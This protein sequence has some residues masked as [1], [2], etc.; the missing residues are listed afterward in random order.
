MTEPSSDRGQKT[1]HAETASQDLHHGNRK[2]ASPI[3][4]GLL[5]NA[6]KSA[7]SESSRCEAFMMQDSF[8]SDTTPAIVAD[9]LKFEV[10]NVVGLSGESKGS[11]SYGAVYEVRVGGTSRIAKRLHGILV[12]ANVKHSERRSVQEKFLGECLLLSKLDHPNIVKFI[13]V[14]FHLR[15]W[16]DVTLIMER[17]HMDLEKF[18][19]PEKTIPFPTKL[20]ILLD[21]SSGLLYLHNELESPVIH[22]DLTAGNVLLSED[23]KSAKIADLGVS[24]LLEDHTHRAVTHTVCPGTF[25]YMP[26][27]ALVDNP[28]YDTPLDIFSF[29]HLAL[30]VAL[31]EFP[32]VYEIS[33]E[34]V[35][36]AYQRKEA[37]IFKRKKWFEKLSQKHCLRD[38]IVCCLS[39]EPT[40]RPVAEKLADEL[41]GKMKVVCVMTELEKYEMKEVHGL[42]HG[43]TKGSGSYGVVYEITMRDT[44]RIAKRLHSILVSTEVSQNERQSIQEKFLHECLLLS[45]LDHPNIVKFI[46]VHFNPRDCFDVTLIMECLHMDLDKF[47]KPEI[48]PS[49]I[50]LST[51]LSI[52]LDISSG[53]LYLHTKLDTPIIHRDLTAGNVLL[54]E[55]LKC[56]KIADLGVSKLLENHTHRA[57]THT[58][59]PGALAYMPPE[60]LVD[61]PKYDTPFDIFS[62]GHLVLYVALQEFPTVYEI[63]PE[64]VVK[65]YQQKE[66]EIFKRKKWF[67]K[68]SPEHCLRN[69][70]ICCLSDEPL[71][72]P[73]AKTL[74]DKLKTLCGIAELEK[75]EIKKVDMFTLG[76]SKG[77]ESFAFAYAVKVEGVTRIVKRLHCICKTTN[78]SESEKEIMLERFHNEC[79]LLSR[80]NHPNIVKFI[81]VNF[82]PNDRFDVTLIMEHL[83]MDLQKFLKPEINP[84]TIP[85]FNKLSILLGVSS[86]LLYLHTL[87]ETPIIHR[88]LT[89][90]NILLVEDFHQAKIADLGASKLVKNCAQQTATHTV[91]LG[92]LAYL[93][94]EALVENPK[95]DTPLDIFSFGH[96][97]LYVALQEF[98]IAYEVSIE[99][100]LKACET[101]EV[102]ICR[103]KKWIEKLSDHCLQNVILTCLKDEPEKRPSARTLHSTMKALFEE[104]NQMNSQDRSTK[105]LFMRAKVECID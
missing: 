24:K 1:S 93:P 83:H 57:V 5:F 20:S 15:N 99:Q 105:V 54:S 87:L 90:A 58:V 32:V 89:A 84:N 69:L 96:L 13:G 75:Y 82:N 62:F 14:H 12:S 94:P 95:Y 76:E 25:A 19:K 73:S 68:L 46:G 34:E 6:K 42:I 80:L 36:M 2:G 8:S 29:G 65:A 51:K 49:A 30:Y 100:L 63:S 41:N 55:D 104:E 37:E 79:L 45:K 22:R 10:K 67:G 21:V 60:A 23:L 71:R 50:P 56:A 77:S 85:L 91:C 70:I 17:L 53:L 47:L 26:P 86:G 48:N 103:R 74:N 98:P 27:E 81:G 52:L 102:A 18:L 43:E 3:S 39:D 97:A 88:D 72:R 44:P 66:A 9:L 40:K 7:G 101:N 11:G 33:Q 16:F 28:K 78:A 92:A 31:Q 64:E 35:V 61:N 38:L 4:T 59:C